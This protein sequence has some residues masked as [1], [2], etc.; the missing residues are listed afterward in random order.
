[1]ELAQLRLNLLQPCFIAHPGFR[2]PQLQWVGLR[3]LF[4]SDNDNE[5]KISKHINYMENGD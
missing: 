3:D 5:K 4:R 1:M 2:R